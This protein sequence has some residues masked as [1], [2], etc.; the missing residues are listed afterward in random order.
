MQKNRGKT[1]YL[2][3]ASDNHKPLHRLSYEELLALWP[4]IEQIVECPAC[5]PVVYHRTIIN[6]GSADSITI[7]YKRNYSIAVAKVGFDRIQVMGAKGENYLPH[8][9]SLEELV[10]RL[11]TDIERMKRDFRA[12]A[13]RVREY[14]RRG[15]VVKIFDLA[16]WC[17]CV[18]QIASAICSLNHS[19]LRPIVFMRKHECDVE[20]NRLLLFKFYSAN[21]RFRG[22]EWFVTDPSFSYEVI[23]PSNGQREEHTLVDGSG[24]HPIVHAYSLESFVFQ[25]AQ[26]EG[27]K[28]ALRGC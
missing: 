13:E 18:D 23:I 20:G 3:I 11:E 10:N 14:N 17:D 1:L 8:P 2:R 25:L 5:G 19:I 27:P 12:A 28:R 24:G 26:Y 22:E 4:P 9:D 21:R 15:S 7:H 16:G 6:D